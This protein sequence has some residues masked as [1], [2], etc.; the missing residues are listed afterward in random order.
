MDKY[1]LVP[2]DRYDTMLKKEKNASRPSD[3]S[4]SVPP[5]GIPITDERAKG[6]VQV[7][8]KEA[9]EISKALVDA[10]L[11]RQGSIQREREQQATGAQGDWRQYWQ[12]S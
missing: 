8:E 12:G 5:P 7:T 3:S 10:S 9:E 1:V 4:V 6:G 2:Q 11:A